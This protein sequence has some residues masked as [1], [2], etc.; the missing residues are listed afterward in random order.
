MTE[1]PVAEI[2]QQ[3][4]W[5]AI[6]AVRRR[7]AMLA[8]PL[9]LKARLML[10]GSPIELFRVRSGAR[11]LDH[12]ARLRD[13]IVDVPGGTLRLD[14]LPFWSLDQDRYWQP[15]KLQPQITG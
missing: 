2:R 4:E 7:S 5:W 1:A 9:P 11:R 12:A 13:L 8:K 6:D 3:V 10:S 15:I 14:A